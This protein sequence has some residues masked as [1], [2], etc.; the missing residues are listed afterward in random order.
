[1]HVFYINLDHRTDRRL[2]MEGEFSHIGLAAE[3][4][5]ALTP[6]QLDAD[7]LAEHAART[8]GTQLSLP[9]LACAYS[10]SRAWQRMLDLDLPY[11][12]FFEDDM[13]LSGLLPA[14]LEDVA[15]LAAKVDIIRLETRFQ[16]VRVGR[17]T[18]RLPCGIELRRFHTQ[19]WGMGGYILNASCAARLL[20]DRR[21]FHYPVDDLFFD[22]AS[23][24]FHTFDNRQCD[25]ALCVPGEIMGSLQGD[26][27][28]HSDI[29]KERR[30]RFDSAKPNRFA[31][32]SFAL[33]LK[34][35]REID[36]IWGQ[37]QEAVTAAYGHLVHMTRRRNIK[38][39]P[40]T[41]PRISK[42][43]QS[44]RSGCR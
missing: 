9:E 41:A 1:M 36:R 24:L 6:A 18:D 44:A 13:R 12:A 27:N 25:P 17:T 43:A 21:L 37:V 14:F 3:R 26:P 23:P 4:I 15:P 2:Y 42:A 31:G 33:L 11:A 10:H 20:A 7:V 35:P 19:Q 30:Q 5:T 8:S 22:N 38:F 28:W 32:R 16:S 29:E 39:D 34:L 40:G